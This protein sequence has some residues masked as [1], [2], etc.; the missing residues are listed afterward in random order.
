MDRNAV[1]LPYFFFLALAFFFFA[2]FE[3]LHPAE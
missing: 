1:A 2:I 3:H